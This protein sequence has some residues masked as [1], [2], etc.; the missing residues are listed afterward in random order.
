M[1]FKKLKYFV[2]STAFALGTAS[3]AT[4]TTFTTE[5]SWEAA[6]GTFVTEPFD[7]PLQSFTGVT[8]DVG[9]IGPA[10]SLL[11][12]SVWNDGGPGAVDNTTFS[13]LPG[14]FFGAGAFFDTSVNGE[15]SG[16]TV[17]LNLTGGG[18][19]VITPDPAILGLDNGFFG[20]TSDVS[21]DS[22]T[23]TSNSETFDMDNL[24]FG[25]IPSSATPE[26]ATF[27]L[28]GIGIAGLAILRKKLA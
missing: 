24:E 13:Y 14:P 10:R 22:F 4:I 7:G 28:I 1:N 9:V 15:G 17:T 19:Q 23:L 25:G 6:A 27:S 18:T 26:P 11:S 20:F 2:I 3:A 16:I 5:S 21:I 12:G 8:T